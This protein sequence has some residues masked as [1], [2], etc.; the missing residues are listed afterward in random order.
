MINFADQDRGDE[1]RRARGF[2]DYTGDE[3]KF[4]GRLRVM[5]NSLGEIVCE[6]CGRE[7]STGNYLP[8]TCD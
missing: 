2:G 7:Q 8:G 3:C 1:I 4:C 6:K 5:E